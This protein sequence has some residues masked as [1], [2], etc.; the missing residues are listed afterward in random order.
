MVRIVALVLVICGVGFGLLWGSLVL[1][2][3]GGWW[4]LPAVVI[5]GGGLACALFSKS[6]A[7]KY[8]PIRASRVAVLSASV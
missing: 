1:A 7:P 2:E 4:T 5:H 8:L 3:R 6:V